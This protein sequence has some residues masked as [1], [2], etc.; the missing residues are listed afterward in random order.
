MNR[1]K[2]VR[3]TSDEQSSVSQPLH[4]S[5][6]NERSRVLRDST[7]QSPNLESHECGCE[8]PFLR[9]ELEGPTIERL[10]GTTGEEVGGTVCAGGITW[11]NG[12]VS[13]PLNEDF[14]TFMEVEERSG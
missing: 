11:G 6:R 10:E 13:E 7:N 5:T 2:L 14:G 8:A 12:E 4:S 3:L 9:E 1:D